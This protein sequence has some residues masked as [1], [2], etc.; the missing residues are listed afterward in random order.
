MC[1]YVGFASFSENLSNSRNLIKKM[2]NVLTKRGPDEDGYY[3]DDNIAMGHKRLIVI[4]PN[5]WKTTYD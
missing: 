5:R 2:N 4:D 1:G 3:I